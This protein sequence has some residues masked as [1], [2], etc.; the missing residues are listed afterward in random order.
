MAFAGVG[1]LEAERGYVKWSILI[2]TKESRLGVL[3]RMLTVIGPQVAEFHNDVEL[4]VRTYDPKLPLG[5]SR[6]LLIDDAKG[7]YVSFVD[8]DDLVPFDFV[9]RILP[10]L[11]PV[12]M[13]GFKV[14][15]WIDGK[16]NRMAI[17]SLKCGKWEEKGGVCYRDLSHLNPIRTELVRKARFEGIRGEDHRWAT[18]LRSLGVVKTEKFIDDMLYLYV[19]RNGHTDGEY[20]EKAG[21]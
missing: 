1:N 18:K 13:V 2:L 21:G 20:I 12:D 9:R 5:E 17:H 8:D 3:E 7:D 4:L 16:W 19:Y 14:G 10:E 6:Q 15:I 11:G